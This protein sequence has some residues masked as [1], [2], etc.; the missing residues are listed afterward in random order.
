MANDVYLDAAHDKE[1]RAA[2]HYLIA[3][4]YARKMKAS[5]TDAL[6]KQNRSLAYQSAQS[7]VNQN[8]PAKW[9]AGELAK[10]LL[11]DLQDPKYMGNVQEWVQKRS[12]N[13]CDVNQVNLALSL[14]HI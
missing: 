10:K 14:I 13:G 1:R 7:V 5:P 2:H 8:Y 9:G 6:M 11:T 4:I 12:S 3:D